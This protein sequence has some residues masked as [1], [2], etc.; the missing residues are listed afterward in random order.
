MKLSRLLLAAAACA[1]APWVMAQNAAPT[2]GV[3]ITRV[4]SEQWEIR[5]IGGATAGQFSAT[6]ES[7][8]P[9]SNVSG[10]RLENRDSAKLLSPNT[11]GTTLAV[12]AG[13][14]DGVNFTVSGDAQ[15][16]LRDTGSSGVQFY[17][18]D[19][20]KT[21]VPVSAPVALT[22]ADA[23]GGIA[24]D[25]LALATTQAT[26]RRKFHA[27]HYIALMRKGGSQQ[28]MAQSIKPGVQGFMKRYTWRALEPSKGHYN[29]S[30]IAS[31]LAWAK[32]HGMHLIVMVEDRTFTPEK[33]LPI[34]L[35]KYQLPSRSGGFCTVRWNPTVISAW[36]AMVQAMGRQFDSHPNFEG[37]ATQET[38]LGFTSAQLKTWAYTPE[39]YR[40]G[41]IKELSAAAA[42]M[43]TSRVFW[44]M[45]F[46]YGNQNYIGQIANAVASKGVVMGGPDVWPDNKALASRTYPF[47]TQ[48]QGKMPLFG[49][50]EDLCY[51]ELHMTGGYRTKYW[52]MPELFTYARTKMHVN[53]MFW[54]R[55][56]Q[57]NPRDSYDWNDALRVV[58]TTRTW[59]P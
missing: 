28:I 31:D 44:M 26:G 18:G 58:A 15:L 57:A 30:E 43:P 34:Y 49:Q 42:A 53:Y 1:V 24:P 33:T 55:I 37:L 10:V 6:I 39:K 4:N 12:S 47:Y 45:N 36:I 54:V 5:L 40:D 16:C 20:L 17:M 3:L 29:F 2:S 56:T 50:V 46:F 25:T 13:E 27:G 9:I 51:H 38:S 14:T 21:A 35:D 7:N 23:C 32:A 8:M 22:T 59:T 52:T 11:L 41:Y 48:M 19:A